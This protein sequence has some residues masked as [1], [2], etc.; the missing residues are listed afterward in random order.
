[1]KALKLISGLIMGRGIIK[2]VGIMAQHR[3][4]G[5]K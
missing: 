1:M 5:K 2:G 4:F 3:R